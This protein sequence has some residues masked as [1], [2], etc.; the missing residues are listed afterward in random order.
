MFATPLTGLPYDLKPST[1][2]DLPTKPE[3]II[4]PVTVICI[5]SNADSLFEEKYL[6][7]KLSD[8]L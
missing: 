8:P 2:P 6:R 4:P 7:P 1:P 3:N 5:F